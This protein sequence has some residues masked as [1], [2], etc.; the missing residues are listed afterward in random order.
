MHYPRVAGRIL[1]IVVLGFLLP[2]PAAVSLA[3]KID[4]AERMQGFDAYMETILKEWNAPAVGV[5]IV[6]GDKLVFSKG[7]G[8]RD[9]GKELPFTPKTLCPIASNSKLFTAVAA[10]MLVEEGK[11]TW[12][13]PI[14]H[15]VPEI[16]FHSDHLNNTVSL[17][18]MLGHR[19]GITRH[20]S[21]WYKSDFSRTELFD[22]TR[23]LKPR[24]P[25]RHL[26]L[27]NNLMYAAVGHVIE[28]KT[29]KTWEAFV[30]ERILVPLE[31]KKTGYSIA[32]MREHPDHGVPYTERRDSD[33][34][35]PLP[36]YEETEGLAPAG[37]I[38]SNVDEVSHWL[39]ALMNGGVYRGKQVL[40]PDVLKATMTPSI[41]QTNPFGETMGYWELL[42]PAYGMGRW[43]ASY[44][45][46][47]LV[48]HGG[49][50][51]G[52]H[53]QISFM[54][55]E[56]VGVIV[57]VIGDHCSKL[58]NYVSYNLYERLLGMDETPWSQRMLDA[59]LKE[60]QADKEGRAKAG[61]DRV[62]ETRP[63]HPLADYAGEYE[64]AAYGIVTIAMK[65]GQLGFSFNKQAMPLAHYHYDRFDTPDD[66]RHQKYSLNF[67][68]NPQGAVER[69]TMFLDE[70]EVAFVRK[71]EAPPV[72]L[73]EI[74][75]GT[76]TSPSG[77]RFQVVLQ[78]G[79]LRLAIPGRP[80]DELTPYRGLTFRNRH[81]SD[82]LFEFVLKE[83]R[84][85]ALRQT[86]PTGQFTFTRE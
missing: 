52:F 60:K 33:E 61:A 86:G 48:Y 40:P 81:N 66:E 78:G 75:A 82:L 51:G 73:L 17:R 50:L 12:D 34:L 35:Y 36:Y 41:V 32:E 56:N 62:P 46:R 28:L 42:N 9:H 26:F 53:T 2:C 8:Y 21:I 85:K 79:S 1:G 45:G 15:A 74:L 44:R 67:D 3:G 68:T 70:A 54:P 20:D 37:A 31:M 29:G 65:G 69:F 39:I 7:Y 14:R 18:D 4:V 49:D 59:R 19:T 64:N 30:R 43:T 72:E 77:S 55:N 58:Y 11:L 16:R 6:V 71:R 63:S 80:M 57:F 23:H 76:Y 84:V 5:G 13:E 38:I 27:Y 25:M 22:R 10:G 83:G 47:L 24:E